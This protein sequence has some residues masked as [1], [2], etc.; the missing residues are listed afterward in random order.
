MGGQGKVLYLRQR[1]MHAR[2]E[3]ATSNPTFWRLF[4]LL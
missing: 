2:R 3:A 1:L 4:I